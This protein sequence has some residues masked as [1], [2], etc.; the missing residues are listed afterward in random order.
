MGHR[1]VWRPELAV[2]AKGVIG[3]R[4]GRFNVIRREVRELLAG[5]VDI[6]TPGTIGGRFGFPAV[7]LV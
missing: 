5:S 7:G 3:E 1:R 2:R 6:E 4:L